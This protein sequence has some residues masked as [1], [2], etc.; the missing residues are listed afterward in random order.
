[1]SGNQRFRAGTE[2]ATLEV[3]SE[4]YLALT[5]RGYTAA[6]EVLEVA[7]GIR[8]EFLIGGIK[9]LAERLEPLRTS[10]DGAFK[11]LRLRIKKESSD[12]FSPYVVYSGDSAASSGAR[13]TTEDKLW[14]RVTDAYRR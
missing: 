14:D 2:F 8:Y 1:M 7:T 10:N 6:I 4:P 13:K 3:T 11:G 9:S 5:F 12:P